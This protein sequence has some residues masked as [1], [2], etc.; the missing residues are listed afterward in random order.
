[1]APEQALG[2]V[3]RL[4]ERADVFGLGAILC[5]VLTGQPPYAGTGFTEAHWQAV[6]ADLA[7]AFDRLDGCGADAELVALCKRCLAA[8]PKDRPRDA[9]VVAEELSAYLQGVEQ[10]LRQAELARAQAEVRVTEERRRRRVQ[11]AL[12]AA[13]VGLLL[14]GGGGGFA[15]YRQHELRQLE[16]AQR[17]REQEKS[18]L[19]ALDKA[20]DL[21]REARWAEAQTLLRQA[22]EQLGMGAPEEARARLEK[23]LADVMLVAE[24]DAIR[25]GKATW[26][27]GGFDQAKADQTYAQVFARDGLGREGEAPEVVA[28]RVRASAVKEPLLAALDDWAFSTR[29]PNRRVWLLDVARRVD[30][31]PWRDRLRD[32][33]LWA[34]PKRLEKLAAEAEGQE[35]TPQAAVGLA[36]RLEPQ[37]A[38]ALLRGV[39]RRHPADFWVNFTLGTHLNADKPQD[40]AGF[41]RAAVAS[42]PQ[43]SAAHNNLA[44]VLEGQ[45]M[46][47]EAL[48][49]FRKAI[50]I[51]PRNSHF[52]INLGHALSRM[53]RLTE[54]IASCRHAIQLDPNKPMAHSALG[55]ALRGSGKADEAIECQRHAIRLD[56]RNAMLYTNLGSTLWAGRKVD[57]AIACFRQAIALDPRYARAHHGLGNALEVKRKVDEAIECWRKAMSLD[58]RYAGPHRNLG[59]VL[60]RQRKLDEAIACFRQAIVLNPRDARAHYELGNALDD[61]G[62]GDEAIRCYRQSIA[63][64]PRAAETH[65][66]LG[67][68]LTATGKADEAIECHRRALA[69]NPRLIRAHSNLG[70]SL[71]D[72][73]KLDD[74]IACFR[75]AIELAPED[76]AAH[77]GLGDALYRK[78]MLDESIACYQKALALKPHNAPALNNLGLALADRGKVDEAIGC[79][80]QALGSDPRLA[81]AHRNLARALYGKGRAAEAVACTL[82]AL[83]LMPSQHPDRATVLLQLEDCRELARLEEKVPAVLRGQV[84]PASAR[85]GLELA[86][87]CQRKQKFAAAAR[88]Y[89][90]GFALHSGRVDELAALYRYNAACAAAQAACGQG[91]DSTT[92]TAMQRLALRR[93]ALTWLNAELGRGKRLLG[94]GTISAK[95][96]TKVLARWQSD[97]HLA[98]LRELAALKQLSGQER[99]A[100]ARFWA[101]VARCRP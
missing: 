66:N 60:L 44:L 16:V 98:S 4:D 13:I 29:A 79:Y 48:A 64:D 83:E 96:V 94:Q 33:A 68:S 3:D 5:E 74:A 76:P 72:K 88:L 82:R 38:A 17:Q 8:E 41:L 58:P 30:P 85:E 45:G 80:R 27:E 7:G 77:S 37:Q 46:Q 89:V 52:H 42:R 100:C 24:L 21:Q 63:L 2:N 47:D 56:P 57:E 51:D 65:T 15:L 81:N 18:A 14:V 59:V 54:A 25:L 62:M 23:A 20:A 12:A 61:K 93:Q 97:P 31:Q 11:L 10:R 28:K 90:E 73:G 70:F 36:T 22:L 78:K 1:M 92:L 75:K 6:W 19:A 84:K 69:L 26:T 86:A 40:A 43:A 99:D 101:A 9:G 91:E 67:V 71:L 50:A 34:D 53:G 49:C 87:L 39:Q 32:P 95:Q 55:I 35:L